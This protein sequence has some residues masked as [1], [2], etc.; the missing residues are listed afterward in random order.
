MATIARRSTR[1]LRRACFDFFG[2][3]D[4]RP[5]PAHHTIRL[6]SAWKRMDDWGP[7]GDQ[8]RE[9]SVSLPDASVVSSTASFVTYRRCFNRP[10]GLTGG[11]SICLLCG[12]LPIAAAIRFNGSAITIPAESSIEVGDRLLPH[13]ELVI[14]IAAEQF[15]AA[16]VASASLQITPV[17]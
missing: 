16:A 2:S 6:H 9:A 5:M 1:Y 10:T 14:R 11:D 12:L 15:Q 7:A 17:D 3:R 4:H 8:Q 13:N